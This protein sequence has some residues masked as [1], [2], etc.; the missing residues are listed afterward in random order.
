MTARSAI[1]RLVGVTIVFAM[2]TVVFAASPHYKRGSP[3]CTTSGDPD[4]LTATCSGDLAGLGNEDVLITVS[5]TASSTPICSAPG[6]PENQVKGQNPVNVT[7]SDSDLFPKDE[8]KNGTLHFGPITATTTVEV[9]TGK[10]A[11]CPNDN[12]NVTLGDFTVVAK[13]TVE[14][15]P[16]TVIDSL[17]RTFP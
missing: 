7:A 2:T 1:R 9:P 8:I 14:Q 5:L 4:N 13:L 12:W 15:P 11:G 16:G 3:Q 17:T 6:N 10:A